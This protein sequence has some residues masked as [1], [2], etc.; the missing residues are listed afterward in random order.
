MYAH[1]AVCSGSIPRCLRVLARTITAQSQQQLRRAEQHGHEGMQR[2]REGVDGD[3]EAAPAHALGEL[4]G[5]DGGSGG[6]TT[7]GD[8]DAKRRVPVLLMS[9][10]MH[11]LQG[12]DRDVGA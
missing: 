10:L 1:A 2:Q 4:D 3:V 7:A 6:G 9:G 5:G 12:G 8:L 11:S